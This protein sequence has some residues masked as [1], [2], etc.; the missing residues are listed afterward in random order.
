MAGR[1][2]AFAATDYNEVMRYRP[3]EIGD[4]PRRGIRETICAILAYVT[5]VPGLMLLLEAIGR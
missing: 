1:P 3:N 2:M 5:V 4:P